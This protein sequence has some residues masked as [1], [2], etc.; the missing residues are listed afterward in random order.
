MVPIKGL[1]PLRFSNADLEGR[2]VYQ[3]HHIGLVSF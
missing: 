1:E 3:F 2:C